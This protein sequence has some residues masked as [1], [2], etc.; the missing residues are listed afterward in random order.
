MTGLRARQKAD[1]ERRILSAAVTQ[2][3]ADG[4]RAVR[5]ED[6]AEAAQVSVGTVYNYYSTKGDILIAT[7]AMEVEEVLASG[8]ALVADPPS[9]VERALLA[10]IFSYYDHS[11]EYLSKEMWRTAMALAIEAPGTPNGRRYSDLDRRLADQ[12]TA[13]VAALQGRGEVRTELDAGALGEVLFNNLNQMF[14]EFV[15]DD[16]MTLEAL[17][18]RVTAQTGPIARL[19]ATQGET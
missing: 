15:K 7:V 17:K 8:A 19:I 13:L 2:F 12:V 3:R 18:A 4:Y 6:L 16:A 1:R 14:L 11:L 9:G 5:I 10:L